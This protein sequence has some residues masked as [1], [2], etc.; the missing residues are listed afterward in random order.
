MIT[1]P[2]TV[3]KSHRGNHP[4]YGPPHDLGGDPVLVPV[5]ST[6]RLVPVMDVGLGWPTIYQI[7]R[8]VCSVLN[9]PSTWVD[10]SFTPLP[11]S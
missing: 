9:I 2:R 7:S 4:T 3:P 6:S 5:Q 1:V 8:I 10:D 11:R